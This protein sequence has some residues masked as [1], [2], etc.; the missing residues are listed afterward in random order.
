MKLWKKM[1]LGLGV[2]AVMALMAGP[3]S[4]YLITFDNLAP[5]TVIDGVNLGG[6]TIF[7]DGPAQTIVTSPGTLWDFGVGWRTAYN[8]ITNYDGTQ[9]GSFIHTYALNIV[10]DVPQPSMS[11][12]GGDRGGTEVDQFTVTAYDVND[13]VLGQVTTPPFGGKPFSTGKMV[14]FYTVNLNFDGIKKV[15][16]SN[17]LNPGIGIDDIQFCVV[18]TPIPGSVLLLGSALLG[19]VGLRRKF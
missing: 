18:P 16:V 8:A 2:L 7:S 14:D 11:L 10:F 3:A 1:R 15:V 9:L 13:V 4:A 12:T 17:A 6:V 5:G 19:L